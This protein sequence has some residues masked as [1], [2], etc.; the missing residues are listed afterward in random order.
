[1]RAGSNHQAV[2]SS[3][4]VWIGTSRQQC[5]SCTLLTRAPAADAVGET[6]AHRG[7]HCGTHVD[8]RPAQSATL[9]KG[10]EAELA[11]GPERSASL[12]RWAPAQLD[13]RSTHADHAR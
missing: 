2:M 7:I 8:E 1:M 13:H 6:V 9:P 5:G 3:R 4:H 11:Y 10:R 12:V